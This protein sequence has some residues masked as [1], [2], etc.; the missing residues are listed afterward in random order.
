MNDKINKVLI[1]GGVHGNELTGVHLV[2][3]WLLNPKEVQFNSFKTQLLIANPKAIENNTR[4]I[5]NDL[6]RAFSIDSLNSKNSENSYENTLAK[7][8]NQKIGFKGSPKAPDFA[9]DIHNSTA[10][11][12]ISLIF[13]KIT[14]FAKK[15]FAY[16]ASID[17]DIKLYYM[18]ND[19]SS[20]PTIAKQDLCLE[21]GPQMHGTLNSKLYFKAKKIVK[22]ILEFIEKW[23]NNLINTTQTKVELYTDISVLDYPRNEDGSLAAM[24]HPDINNKNYQLL[25]DGDK[26]FVDFNNNDISYTPPEINTKQYPTFIGEEA[27]YEKSIAMNLTKKTIE[28]W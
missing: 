8:I 21:I 9:I 20:F 19:K 16:L 14:P 3:N 17:S 12:G 15:L 28:H 18:P 11:M 10:N 7:E 24:L 6:N 1:S 25:K 13:A 23:N 27:Y 2:K 5:D 4:Y 22:E 26:I